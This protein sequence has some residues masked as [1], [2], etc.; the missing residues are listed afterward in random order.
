MPLGLEEHDLASLDHLVKR[1]R[2]LKKGDYLYRLGDPLHSLYA[3]RAGTFKSSGFL[4]DGRVHI[5]G[6]YLPG[7]L[8]G[9]DA[10]NSDSHPCNA[11]ALEP[12][13]VCE[14]PFSALE[15]FTMKIPGLQRQLLRIMSGEIVRDEQTLM[16]LG[17]MTA[18]ERFASC[19]VS[20]SRRYARVGVT[21][22]KFR[23]GMSR[24]DLG[25]YL[26]LALETVSRLF[27][28]FQEDGLITVETRDI[29]IL[30]IEK[31]EALA[32]GSKACHFN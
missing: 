13:E 23:L 14:I 29:Q 11:Q 9:M 31:L 17:R 19:L 15:D 2:N 6:F 12:A 7:E 8:L 4:E 30:N 24:Q 25:D 20:F 16:M 26:G 1:R 21:G 10:I 3:V 27:S 28:K 5:T 18:E 32:N 22:G